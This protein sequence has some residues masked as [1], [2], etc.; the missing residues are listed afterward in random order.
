MMWYIAILLLGFL[1]GAGLANLYLAR[2]Q[3][4]LHLARAELE[5]RLATASEELAQLKESQARQ[6]YQVITAI[7]PVITFSGDKPP[8]VEGRAAT[9]AITREVQEI[10]SPLMGQEVRRLNPALIPGMID[11]R[12]MKVNGRQFQLRVTL[13]LISDRVVIHLQARSLPGNGI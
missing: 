2:Q 9:Q 3:E 12:T 6:S 4:Q 13:V 5:Q 11:G 8:A 7:E 10:L 1:L